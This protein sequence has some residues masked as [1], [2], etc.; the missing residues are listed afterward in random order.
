MSKIVIFS[1]FL[2]LLVTIQGCSDVALIDTNQEIRSRNW[3]YPQ[4]VRIPVEIKDPDR[5][6]NVYMNLRHTADYKYSNIFV[7]IHQAGPGMKNLTER[8]EFKLAYPDGEW[9]GSGSGNFYSY[10]LP[11][12]ENYKFPAKGTYTFEFEQN[13]RDNPLREVSDVGLRVEPVAK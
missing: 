2:L 5:L 12:R 13:M 11:F 6:Y 3:S 7:L 10:Q 4:K 9:L 8:R 1:C